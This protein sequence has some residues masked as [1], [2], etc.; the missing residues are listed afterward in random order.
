MVVIM[1]EDEQIDVEDEELKFPDDYYSFDKAD[2]KSLLQGFANQIKLAYNLNVDVNIEGEIQK[3]V[4]SGMGGSAIAGDLLKVYLHEFAKIPVIVNRNYKLP[5]HCDKNTLVV[6]SSYSGNTEETVSAY[7]DAIRKSCK[8]VTITSGGKLSEM[9][10]LNRTAIIK[11]PR[12]IQ[13]RAAIG[14]SFFPML[15]LMEKLRIIGSQKK[16]VEHLVKSLDKKIFSDTGINL[17]EKLVGKTPLIYSSELFLPVAYRWKTQFNENTKIMALSN[18]FSELNHNEIECVENPIGEMYCIIIRTDLDP[19]RIAKRMEVTK[20]IY[21]RAGIDVTEIGI[22]GESF[23]TKMFSA[24]S[25]GDW[26]SYYLAL[27]YKID[28]SE[29]RMIEEF[30]KTL[31]TYIA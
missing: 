7:K 10:V 2:M 9:S 13:P 11:I 14:Y 18:V 6:I 5:E 19:H 27:R 4:V 23:L 8:I 17:S 12:D 30:K 26:T 3:V 15:K 24:I 16:E 20:E 28:P 31:G 21:K 29:V 25:M 22:K 1:A